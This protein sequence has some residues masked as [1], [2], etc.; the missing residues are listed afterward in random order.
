MSSQVALDP[1]ERRARAP[2]CWRHGARRAS[3]Q[4]RRCMAPECG[5]RQRL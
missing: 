3:R 4:H 5:Y 1:L 2:L